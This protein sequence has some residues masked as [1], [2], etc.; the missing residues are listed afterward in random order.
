MSAVPK[1]YITPEQYLERERQAET[2]SEYFA[3][4]IFA[5]AGGSPE[6]SLISSNVLGDLWPQ[7]REGPC[8]AYSSDMKVRST[9]EH[10]AYPDVTVVFGEAEFGGE[11]REVLLNPTLIV[12]VLSSTTEAWDR[13]WKFEQYRQRESL[14]EYVL[15]AQ[16]RPHVERFARQADGQ[17]LLTE[18]NGLEASLFLASIGCELA[19]SEVYRKV[20]FPGKP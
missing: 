2:K 8:T 5:M 17:W 7:L 14:Q 13:G 9:Q 10:F 6:H 19:L 1:Q 16:D 11:E 4:E 15:V 20:T 12:E 3:G 18:R